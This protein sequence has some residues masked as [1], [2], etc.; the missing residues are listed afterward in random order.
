LHC[1]ISSFLRKSK[2]WDSKDVDANSLLQEIRV[3]REKCSK[4]KKTI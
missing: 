2:G 3:R 4:A 1:F